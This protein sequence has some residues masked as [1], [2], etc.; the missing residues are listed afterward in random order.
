MKFQPRDWRE[1]CSPCP[2]LQ[3]SCFAL[4]LSLPWVPLL[5]GALRQ[6]RESESPGP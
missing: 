4:D 1:W 3:P 6:W 5:S 2:G